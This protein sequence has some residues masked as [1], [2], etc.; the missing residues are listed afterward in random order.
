P[1]QCGSVAAQPATSRAQKV[2]RWPQQVVHGEYLARAGDCGACHTVKGEEAYAGGAP[3]P[4]PFGTLYGP[5]IT[6]DSETGIGKWTADDF[7]RALHDGRSKYGKLLYPA[8]PYT[9]YTKVVRADADDLFAYLRSVKPVRKP[10][11]KHELTFPYNQ[12]KLLIGWRALYFK[13]GEYQ[14]DPAQSKEWN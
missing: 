13:P 8:F 14:D 9:N 5:N 7:W 3:I 1:L 4:T 12:R 10:S 2:E 11:R 6:P